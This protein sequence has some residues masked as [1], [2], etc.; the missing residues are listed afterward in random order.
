MKKIFYILVLIFL[1]SCN[2]N[3]KLKNSSSENTDSL[4]VYLNLANNDDLAD[5]Q[6]QA[7][8]QKAFNIVSNQK[9]DTVTRNNLFKITLGFYKIKDWAYFK[10]TSN[11]LEKKAIEK[12]DTASLA[13]VYRY[14]AAYFKGLAVHDSA[15]YFYLKSEKFYKKINDK[16]GLSTVL[17]NKSI[18]QFYANDYSGADRSLTQAYSVLRN[19]DDKPKLYEVFSM[20]GIISNELKDYDKAV[21]YYNK[22]LKIITENNLETS[23]HEIATCLNNI[24][25][26]YQNLEKYDEAIRYYNKALNEKKILAEAPYLYSVLIDNLAYSKFK[27]KDHKNLP[28]LFYKSL[29]VRDSIEAP[30]LIVLSKIHLSEYYASQKDSLLSQKF[31]KEALS[32]AKSTHIPRDLLASLK[33]SS[34]VDRINASKYTKDYIRINDSIQEVERKSQEKFAR[35]QLETNEIIEQKD[36]LEEK[37]RN[38]LLGFGVTAII[39]GLLFVVRLQRA[40]TRELLYKQAQQKANEDIYN[41]MM[42]QQA[43]IDESREKEK[44]RLAQDLHDGILGRMFGLRLNLDSLNSNTDTDST[45]RRFELLNELKTIEQDIREISH[46]LNREKLVLINNFVSIVHNLLEEQQTSHEAKLIHVLDNNIN[47]DTVSNAA[48]INM[49]RILQEGLQNINKYANAKN[50]NVEI[51]GNEENISLVIKDDGV[52]FDVNK[53]SKGIGMQN[54]IS[55]THDCKGIIDVSSKKGNGTI[56]TITIPKETKQLIAEQ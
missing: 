19:L 51:K 50:I 14:K 42:S 20:M 3:E 35:L 15:F 4:S 29:K 34:I 38:L 36:I 39:A 1:Y 6:K 43:I 13:K 26:A 47:W 33:Q 40:R 8:Y 21:E 45:Q 2:K 23:E 48:K 52:G 22:A 54:M 31:A 56:I 25:Y 16:K 10:K 24:G 17:V 49:Y 44:K 28:D 46:D 11:L 9:N 18:V 5:T 37:N 53:K 27:L 30:T 12:Q 7:N 32:L 41:L 55:R